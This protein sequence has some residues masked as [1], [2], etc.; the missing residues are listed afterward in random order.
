MSYTVG[1]VGGYDITSPEGYFTSWEVFNLHSVS[2]AYS[3][4]AEDVV[5]NVKGS[6]PSEFAD[7]FKGILY[8]REEKAPGRTWGFFFKN[9]WNGFSLPSI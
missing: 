4:T 7:Y 9:H 3:S 8:T 5:K 6:F 2:T 1:F